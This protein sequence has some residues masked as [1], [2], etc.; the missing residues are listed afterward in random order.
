MTDIKPGYTRVSA[1]CKRYEDFG[2]V[3]PIYLKKRAAIGSATHQFIDCHLNNVPLILP[4]EQSICDAALAYYESWLAWR[5][6]NHCQ[7]ILGEERIYCDKFMMTGAIDGIVIFP[8]CNEKMIVDWKT[9]TYASPDLWALKG[10]FYHYLVQQNNL[11]EIADKVLFVQLDRD[12]GPATVHE[13]DITKQLKGLM[14]A[15]IMCH[16]FEEKVKTKKQECSN[17]E[18]VDKG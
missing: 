2:A 8:G 7:V 18:S 13:Y 6:Q 14:V 15:T 12:G 10:T 11:C 5:A 3:D 16:R 1:F 17:E 9:S 4:E